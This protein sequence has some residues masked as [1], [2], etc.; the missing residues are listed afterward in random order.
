M[1]ESV[2]FVIPFLK[3]HKATV[4]KGKMSYKCK[5]FDKNICDQISHL[6]KHKGAVHEGKK[7]FK[8]N[9][10]NLI[11]EYPMIDTL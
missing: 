10:C 1:K 11:F 7:P 9:I 2:T 3:K 8:C 4:N 5:I 6:R